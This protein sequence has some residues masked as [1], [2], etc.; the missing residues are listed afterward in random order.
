MNSIFYFDDKISEKYRYAKNLFLFALSNNLTVVLLS[1]FIGFVFL[2][3]FTKLINSTNVL[4]EVF[5]KEEEKMKANKKYKVTDERKKEIIKEIE[6]ILK[7]H[8]TKVFV[9]MFIE[10]MLMLFF[11]YYVTVFCHVYSSTQKSWLI[12]SLLTMLSRIIINFLLCLGF[13]KLYR[14]AVEANVQALYKLSLFFY[15]FC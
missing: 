10:F 8:K 12:D 4:R 7:K 14:M 1:T 6:K 2:T 5:K 13:A 11:W 9:F 15:S 3:F